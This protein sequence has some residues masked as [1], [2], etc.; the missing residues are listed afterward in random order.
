MHALQAVV[1][2][3]VPP[4]GRFLASMFSILSCFPIFSLIP[5]TT[6]RSETHL[7]YLIAFFPLVFFLSSDPLS[8]PLAG[9]QASKTKQR[10]TKT[11][12][13]KPGASKI[14][15]AVP[16]RRANVSN[17]ACGDMIKICIYDG[18]HKI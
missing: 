6:L 5:H 1:L 17:Q 13:D 15:P 14:R 8:P 4:L 10:Q 7:A 2:V 12:L 18:N 11:A 16:I 3:S 9:F